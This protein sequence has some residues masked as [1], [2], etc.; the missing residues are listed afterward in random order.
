MRM[1]RLARMTEAELTRGPACDLQRFARR[2]FGTLQEEA[3][4]VVLRFAASL[5]EDVAEFV[6][7][8]DQTLAHNDDGSTTVRFTPGGVEEVYWHL[9]IWGDCRHPR[10]PRPSAPAPA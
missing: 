5:G 6:F 9:V 3:V 4:Q 1:W 10:A 2:S 8:P 7:Q